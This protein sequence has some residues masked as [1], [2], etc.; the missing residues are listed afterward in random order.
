MAVAREIGCASAQHRK[1]GSTRICVSLWWGGQWEAQTEI[2]HMCIT[3][4]PRSNDCHLPAFCWSIIESAV[5]DWLSALVLHRV[6]LLEPV[7]SQKELF[8][9]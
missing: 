5:K 6:T 9:R 3:E 8:G 1:D 4:A 7:Q 2:R